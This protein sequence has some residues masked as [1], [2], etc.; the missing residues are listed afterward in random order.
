[1]PGVGP[2]KLGRYGNE[3]LQTLSG[4]GAG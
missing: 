2:A 4:A 3:I 1:V